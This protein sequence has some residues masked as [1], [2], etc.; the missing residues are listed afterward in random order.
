MGS[1][2]EGFNWTSFEVEIDEDEEEET[3][4]GNGEF[5]CDREAIVDTRRL[6]S[7][8][9]SKFFLRN[10]RKR[11]FSRCRTSLRVRSFSKSSRAARS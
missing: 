9:L 7:V 5:V 6:S 2:I 4:A 3:A 11:S 8:L 10:V 1:C